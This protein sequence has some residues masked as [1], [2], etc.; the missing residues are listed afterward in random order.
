MGFSI[1]WCGFRDGNTQKVLDQL[2]LFQL[3]KRRMFPNRSFTAQLDTGWRII[4]Y[5]EY[6]CPFLRPRPWC[7]SE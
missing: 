7:H 1:T 5:N 6:D 3:A 2:G 4:W